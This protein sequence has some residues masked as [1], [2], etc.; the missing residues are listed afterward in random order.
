MQS[1]IYSFKNKDRSEKSR[2]S[3]E[4]QDIALI[5]QF[6]LKKSI[7]IYAEIIT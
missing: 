4:I 5:T 7:L 2:V 1:L 3:I 6:F